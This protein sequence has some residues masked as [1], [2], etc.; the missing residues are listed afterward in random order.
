MKTA[1]I[2][3]Q[4]ANTWQRPQD[5]YGFTYTSYDADIKID[6]SGIHVPYGK[7]HK[8]RFVLQAQVG[9]HQMTWAEPPIAWKPGKRP[10]DV[11][12]D[13]RMRGNPTDFD[14]VDPADH[15]GSFSFYFLVDD[16]SGT[17]KRS[18]DPTIVN[19]PDPDTPW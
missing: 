17:V 4:G 5:S 15:K 18:K 14:L 6:A 11:W 10:P 2:V 7:A 1:I 3:V 12:E 9:N 8:L 13:R 19:K 16:G